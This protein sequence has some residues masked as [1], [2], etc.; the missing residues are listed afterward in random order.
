M[1]GLEALEVK[2]TLPLILPADLGAKTIE[3]VALWPAP[4]GRGKVKPL[5]V[6]LVPV[7]V[8]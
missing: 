6:K 7:R 2:A 4:S 1:A 3:K 5:R 8:A